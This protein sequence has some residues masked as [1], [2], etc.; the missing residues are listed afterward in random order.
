MLVSDDTRPP[1]YREVFRERDFRV[2]WV[3]HALL[4][5]GEVMK[6]LALSALVYSRSGSPCCP[7]SPTWRDCCRRCSAA[8]PC[9][10]WQ[11]GSRPG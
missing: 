6:A 3:A 1:G 8:P 5:L 10:P 4:N 7:A 2:L 9:S 11:T